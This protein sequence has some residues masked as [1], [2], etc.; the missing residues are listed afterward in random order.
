MLTG[1]PPFVAE[2]AGEVISLHLFAEPEL[3]SARRPGVS[4]DMDRITMRLLAKEP[5]HRFANA[6]EL[7]DALSAAIPT[8]T[9]RMSAVLPVTDRRKALIV[10][11]HSDANIVIPTDVIGGARPMP[12]TPLPI[13]AGASAPAR[14]R[15]DRGLGPALI[16][17]TVTLALAAA[18]VVFLVLRKPDPPARPAPAPPPTTVDNHVIVADPAPPPAQPADISYFLAVTPIDAAIT[19]DGTAVTLVDGFFAL[20]S[21]PDR[22]LIVVSAPGYHDMTVD[23]PGDHNEHRTI[24]LVP[25]GQVVGEHTRTPKHGTTGDGGG[26]KRASGGV[27]ST[28]GGA[29]VG[30]KPPNPDDA[31]T[32]KLD[33]GDRMYIDLGDDKPPPKPDSH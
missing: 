31:R 28:S 30:E 20:P 3:P 17:G 23:V 27:Q 25:V 29:A 13:G 8:L 2:G 21:R 14:A 1:A 10:P 6:A 16:A 11:T 33:S 19:V 24:A 18:V 15:R 5:D 9:G 26:N 4:E 12:T 7:V 32:K 22:R